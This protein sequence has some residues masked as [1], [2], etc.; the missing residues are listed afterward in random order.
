VKNRLAVQ[1]LVVV[2]TLALA[3]VAPEGGGL[4]TSAGD[5]LDA[6]AVARGERLFL[7]SCAG[8]CH[9]P[10]AGGRGDAPDLFDCVWVYGA[11]DAA[12]FRSISEGVPDSDMAGFAD[13]LSE[14]DRWL[15]LTWIRA[16][17]RCEEADPA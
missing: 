15:L 1:Q 8:Y 11:T 9:S 6:S 17:S 7:G 5:P 14:S 2:L 3:C 12:I 13:T 10:A 16:Q 4:R